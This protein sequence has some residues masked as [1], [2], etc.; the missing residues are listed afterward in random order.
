[1]ISTVDIHI[2]DWIM[3]EICDST[4]RDIHDILL[5]IV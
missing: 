3:F 4:D 2:N 5:E 1:M